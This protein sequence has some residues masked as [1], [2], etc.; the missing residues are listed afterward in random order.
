VEESIHHQELMLA[1]AQRVCNQPTA[2][3]S[4]QRGRLGAFLRRVGWSR[5]TG[6]G[7]RLSTDAN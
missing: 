1:F 3:G 4:R 5:L 7:G 2:R 6:H